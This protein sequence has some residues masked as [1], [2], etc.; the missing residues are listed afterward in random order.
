MDERLPPL[1]N[2]ILPG[3]TVG[4]ATLHVGRTVCRRAERWVVALSDE[5]TINSSVLHYVNRLSDWLFIAARYENVL[6]GKAEAIWQSPN[7]LTI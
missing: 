2:F 1:K 7:R 6:K 3:G 5:E 4:V